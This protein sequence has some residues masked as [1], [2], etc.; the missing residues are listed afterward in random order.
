MPYIVL[1][2]SIAK[3]RNHS[4]HKN[5][6]PAAFSVALLWWHRQNKNVFQIWIKQLKNRI[7]KFRLIVQVWKHEKDPAGDFKSPISDG[8][9]V[10]TLQKPLFHVSRKNRQVVENISDVGKP[11]FGS[12]NFLLTNCSHCSYGHASWKES[13][14]FTELAANREVVCVARSSFMLELFHFGVLDTDD[15]CSASVGILLE[16]LSG[17]I[18][19]KYLTDTKL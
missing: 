10:F 5:Y 2:L 15:I 17:F 18:F 13:V 14:I 1:V 19:W 6:N 9:L 4:V 16:H 7:L 8:C 3:Y 12:R 11:T